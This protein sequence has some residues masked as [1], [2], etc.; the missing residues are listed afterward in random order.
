MVGRAQLPGGRPHGREGRDP[1]RGSPALSDC[2]SRRPAGPEWP[3]GHGR[4]PGSRGGGAWSRA[5]GAPWGGGEARTAAL[6]GWG[7]Q[8]PGRAGRASPGVWLQ[9]QRQ[10][11]GPEGHG[12]LGSGPRET[13]PG[14]RAA[15]G[16]GWAHRDTLLSFQRAKEEGEQKLLVLEEAR[17]AAQ[18]EAW[19]LRASLREVERAE[20]D[21]RRGLQELG[22]QVRAA[23]GPGPRDVAPTPGPPGRSEGLGTRPCCCAPGT[24]SPHGHPGA[25][26]RRHRLP[27]C[28]PLG[29]RAEVPEVPGVQTPFRG[30]AL[31]P[32]DSGGPFQAST[33]VSRAHGRPVEAPVVLCAPEPPSPAPPSSPTASREEGSSTVPLRGGHGG[34]EP[35]GGPG[36]REPGSPGAQSSA[37]LPQPAAG[38]RAVS[39]GG[40][41]RAPPPPAPCVQP[42]PT[43][44]APS[45]G[46]VSRGWGPAGPPATPSVPPTVTGQ[47]AGG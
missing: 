26:G 3:A 46:H 6:T 30:G 12:Q 34:T 23:T 41:L 43:R 15:G 8:V 18:K 2:P 13:D 44:R 27:V 47:H 39:S 38:P 4:G 37:P 21:A 40:G 1:N 33:A 7:A 20:A 31:T 45:L 16:A 17:A 24:L 36:P 19:E 9:R 29:L 25:R 14:R 35:C 10:G 42:L 11:E 28:L 22:R 32:L 5:G